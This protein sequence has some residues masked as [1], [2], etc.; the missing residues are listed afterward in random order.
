MRACFSHPRTCDHRNPLVAA[1]VASPSTSSDM[2]AGH[3]MVPPPPS[4]ATKRGGCSIHGKM[5]PTCTSPNLPCSLRSAD[6]E[7]LLPQ[8]YARKG[9]HCGWL[10]IFQNMHSAI[11]LIAKQPIGSGSSDSLSSPKVSQSNNPSPYIHCKMTV[12]CSKM[13][14]GCRLTPFFLMVPA[15]RLRHHVRCWQDNK[16]KSKLRGL[17]EFAN[18]FK[19][20]LCVR[21]APKER[22]N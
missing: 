18:W 13:T 16:G 10:A 8:P 7:G 22:V 14:V 9:R 15:E 21:A 19:A 11:P 5:F 17:V 6:E 4:G 2:S 20:F 1:L 3:D 12:G